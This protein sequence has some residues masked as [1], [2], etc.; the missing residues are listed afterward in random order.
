MIIE[1][2]PKVFSKK[3]FSLMK[4]RFL[5]NLFLEFEKEQGRISTNFRQYKKQWI[6]DKTSN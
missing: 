2:K 6:N 1:I 3:W 5:Q 4:L